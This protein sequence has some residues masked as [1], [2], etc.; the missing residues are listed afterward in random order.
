LIYINCFPKIYNLTTYFSI[1][2]GQ[3]MTF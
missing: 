3:W 1:L 2:K